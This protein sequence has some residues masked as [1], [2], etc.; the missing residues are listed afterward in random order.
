MGRNASRVDAMHAKRSITIMSTAAL[1]TSTIG[2]C[3]RLGQIMRSYHSI[4]VNA[5]LGQ[6]FGNG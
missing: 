4:P 3:G 5:M 2:A 1:S 6:E